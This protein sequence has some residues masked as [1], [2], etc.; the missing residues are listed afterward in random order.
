MSTHSDST[1]KEL[2]HPFYEYATHEREGDQADGE[3]S[4]VKPESVVASELANPAYD[5]TEIKNEV[6]N[7]AYGITEI[8]RKGDAVSYPLY[9]GVP[10]TNSVKAELTTS[11]GSGLYV[12]IPARKD[13]LDKSEQL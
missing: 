10:T 2:K 4:I 6:A 11:S 8:K 3:Y 12:E 5:M 7:P 9:G 13:E 1:V